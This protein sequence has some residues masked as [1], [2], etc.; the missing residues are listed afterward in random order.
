MLDTKSLSQALTA[1]RSRL[2][3][4]DQQIA[5]LKA[6]RERLQKGEEGL[7]ALL[8]EPDAL[9]EPTDTKRGPG[10]P[11]KPREPRALPKPRANTFRGRLLA[12]IQ[13]VPEGLSTPQIRDMF[14]EQ[15]HSTLAGTLS[16]LRRDGLLRSKSGMWFPVERGKPEETEREEETTTASTDMLVSNETDQALPNTAP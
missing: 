12:A 9:S 10:R 6:E 1:I 11:R 16:N 14:P 13:Q 8:A 4:I 5:A 2:A 7:N 3:E 15:K